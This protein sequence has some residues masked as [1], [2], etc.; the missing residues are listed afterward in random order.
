[1]KND[2]EDNN[3]NN[4]QI[5]EDSYE[6]NAQE[7]ILYQ[8][9]KYLNIQGLYLMKKMKLTIFLVSKEEMSHKQR[10]NQHQYLDLLI[11]ILEKQLKK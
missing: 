11:I 2:F 1:M 10:K 6:G 7:I 3:N 9:E 4:S 5:Q 8:N